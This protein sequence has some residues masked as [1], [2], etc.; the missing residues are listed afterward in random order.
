MPEPRVFD[1]FSFVVGLLAL[2]GAGLALLDRAGAVDVDG[3]VTA[4]A[5]LLV[6]GVAGVVKAAMRLRGP[7][8]PG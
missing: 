8:S 6:A 5:F 3:A 4:A 1:G 2:I 7:R